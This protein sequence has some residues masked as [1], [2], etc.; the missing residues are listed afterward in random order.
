M[1]KTPNRRSVIVALL[2]FGIGLHATV[3]AGLQDER[4]LGEQVV[5]LE[6]W[7]RV[8]RNAVR[9]GESF[10]MLLTCSVVEIQNARAVPNDVGL[11]PESLDVRPFEVVDGRRF[12]DI[13]DGPRRL[14][15]YEYTLRIVGEDY[16]GLD[17]ELPTLELTYRIE[18]RLDGGAA[19]P[20]R[21]LTYILPAESI[22]VLSLVPEQTADIRD[23]AGETFGAAESRLFRATM[24]MIVGA[25]LGIL[26][27]GL[28]IVGVV[29][30]RQERRGA[31]PGQEKTVPPAAI[32]R[33]I[34]DE[35]TA[36]QQ[37][38]QTNGWDRE[39]A[40][41][42]LSVFR[43]LGAVATSSPVTQTM[44]ESGTEP[45]DGQLRVRRGLWA[46]KTAVVSSAL[47]PHG[48]GKAIQRLRADHP[49]KATSIGEIDRLRETMLLLT[50]ARYGAKTEPPTDTLTLE[51]DSSITFA[52]RLRFAALSPVR[53]VEGF[54]ASARAWWEQRWAR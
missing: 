18:R 54:V 14:F 37:E 46:P 40:G 6:C 28:L 19:L 48:L 23:L 22:R 49:E 9:V 47:T 34:V 45:R 1:G 26:A 36:L 39:L 13:Q 35:L 30:A 8:D 17:L 42:A 32:A 21:E 43:L 20:G 4:P 52:R 44:V 12:A 41:R 15:Q 10:T 3:D 25:T 7:R 2:A 38:S 53:Y 24:A 33:R 51:L 31:R 11:D 27:L 50:A 16:F 5:A 29:R